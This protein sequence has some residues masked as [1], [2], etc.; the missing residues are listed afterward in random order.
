MLKQV[1]NYICHRNWRGYSP[2]P[3][4]PSL[5]HSLLLM[6]EIEIKLKHISAANE[7]TIIGE[8]EHFIDIDS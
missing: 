3:P 8:D 5:M 2:H 4:A 1:L 7:M 6:A